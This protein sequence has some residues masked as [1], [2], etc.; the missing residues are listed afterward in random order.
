MGTER[1]EAGVGRWA[2]N[3]LCP[4][5]G[6][7]SDASAGT[8]PESCSRQVLRAEDGN[9]RAERGVEGAVDCEEERQGEKRGREKREGGREEGG[10]GVERGVA[11]L[12]AVSQSGRLLG[13][14]KVVVSHQSSGVS[15]TEPRRR[16]PASGTAATPSLVLLAHAAASSPAWC[17]TAPVRRRTAQESR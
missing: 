5:P 17:G 4:F 8:H 1:A 13:S 3:V 14:G 7:K 9:R 15:T 12:L 10:E 6:P 2:G 16:A 11:G